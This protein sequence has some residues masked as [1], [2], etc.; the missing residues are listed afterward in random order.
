MLK[1]NLVLALGIAALAVQF[2]SDAA[3]AKLVA[4]GT[5]F[6]GSTS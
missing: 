3:V 1:R 4:N 2:W 6:N 5:S